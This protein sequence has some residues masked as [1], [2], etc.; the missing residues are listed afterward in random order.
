MFLRARRKGGKDQIIAADFNALQ[1]FPSNVPIFRRHGNLRLEKTGIQTESDA[2]LP[3]LRTH[4]LIP[5][6]LDHLAIQEKG[7]RFLGSKTDGSAGTAQ[8]EE[9][10]ALG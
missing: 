10:A 7:T 2:H 4:R 3:I 1:E 9:E 5:L 6:A 8:P